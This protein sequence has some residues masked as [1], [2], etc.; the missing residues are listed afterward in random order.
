MSQPGLRIANCSGF[1][2][3]RLSAAREM[4]EGGPIDVLTGDYLAELTMAILHKSRTR[5]P[6]TGYAVTFLTQME[7]VLGACLDRGIR[8]VAN[9]GGLNPRGLAEALGAVATRLGLAPRIA[10]VTGDDV[11]DRLARWQGAGHAL[12]H[13]DRGTPLASLSAPVITANAYLGGWGIAEALRLGAD[14]VI[15]GRVTDAALALGPAAWRFGW[16]RDD[17]DRLAAGVVAGHIIECGAQCCGGNYAF[18]QEVPSYDAIGFPICE[19]EADGSFVI[20]KH[21]GTGGLVSRGTVTAQLLYEIDGPRYLNPDVT[22]RFDTIALTDDG[23][24]RVRVSGVRGEPPPPTTKLCLNYLGGFRNSVTF[25]LTG[26]D[27]A[28][29]AKLIENTF[30]KLVGGRERFADTSVSLVRLDRED[31]ESNENAT[32]FLKFTVK[33]PDGAKVGRAFANRA[34]EMALAHYPGFYTGAPPS[35]ATEYAVYWPTVIPSAL[36]EQV[37]HFEGAAVA[38]QPVMPPPGHVAAEAPPPALP[39]QPRGRLVRA[40]LGRVAGARSGDKGGNANVGLW[41]RTPAAYAWLLETLTADRLRQLLPEARGLV[42]ERHPLPNL[43]AVNF[44]IRGL[45]GEGVAASTRSDPQAKSLGEYLRAKV[46]DIP[47][48]IAASL[49]A[50]DSRQAEPSCAPDGRQAEPAQHALGAA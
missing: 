27:I 49:C 47:Q 17:W 5:K 40:P 48:D 15:T 46:L 1:Y 2:G 13:L 21:P 20:T 8:V 4:V 33:D 10:Y 9:A 18:F 30:W 6:G 39:V 28:E 26:L 41:V 34:I 24:D 29:K 11:L 42:V 25:A 38:I 50:P 3:D 37:V 14:V 45:L 12:A 35:E 23:P 31:P 43:L 36:I 19:M 32:A 22:A 7:R 16:R 44:V